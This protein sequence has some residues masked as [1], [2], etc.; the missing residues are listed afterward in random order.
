MHLGWDDLELECCLESC[1]VTQPFL[2]NVCLLRQNRAD[3]GTL[4][5]QVNQT[6]VQDQV[7]HPVEIY[8]TGIA[9]IAINCSWGNAR[10]PSPQKSWVSLSGAAGASPSTCPLPPCNGSRHR[11]LGRSR[12]RLARGGPTLR[13]PR[14]GRGGAAHGCRR[15]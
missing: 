6:R 11:T 14:W 3:S 8:C 5:L 1:L 4:K 13:N 15:W 9:F 7:R 12:R 2:P 10:S